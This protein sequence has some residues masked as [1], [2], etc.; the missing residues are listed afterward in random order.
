LNLSLMF[1]IRSFKTKIIN[2]SLQLSWISFQLLEAFIKKIQ[3]QVE[4]HAQFSWIG[5][6]CFEPRQT[7]T[8]R[9]FKTRRNLTKMQK[10]R[11][12]RCHWHFSNSLFFEVQIFKSSFPK[13]LNLETLA[14]PLTKKL[15]IKKS[16][17]NKFFWLKKSFYSLDYI[18][19]HFCWVLKRMSVVYSISRSQNYEDFVKRAGPISDYIPR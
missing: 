10:N 2:V 12:S 14:A 11:K 4:V 13:N 7:L 9:K 16:D 8:G 1:W 18:K 6:K 17:Q 5:F 19:Y 15:Q 3:L